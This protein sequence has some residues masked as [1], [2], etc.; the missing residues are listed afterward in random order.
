MCFTLFRSGITD[1]PVQLQGKFCNYC[2]ICTLHVYIQDGLLLYA[3]DCCAFLLEAAA[4]A[5]PCGIMC[6]SVFQKK[7]HPK[8]VLHIVRKQTLLSHR[9]TFMFCELWNLHWETG[10]TLDY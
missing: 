9:H 1:E 6:L 3:S 5:L 8:Q 7:S 4:L 10:L 2:I